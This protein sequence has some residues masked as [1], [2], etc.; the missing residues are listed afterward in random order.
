MGE[1]AVQNTSLALEV[2]SHLEEPVAKLLPTLA[3]VQWPGR[4]ERVCV[5]GRTVY[6]SGDHNEQGVES[7]RELL[8]HFEYDRL[9]LV[10]GI[11]KGKPVEAMLA[12]YKRIPRA[13]LIL[14]RTSFRPIDDAS[15]AA[16][17]A[18]TKIDD[19]LEALRFTATRASPGDLVVVSGS[20]YLVG[21]LKAR[22]R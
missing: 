21:D 12:Q 1:R 10:V 15:F 8:S 14:T 22:L 18:E 3:D 5:D 4:M 20:L 17:E 7:L 11:G 16:L 6:L 9:W 13:K 2:L 19:A